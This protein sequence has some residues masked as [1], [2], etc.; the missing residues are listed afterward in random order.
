MLESE[1]LVVKSSS[2]N[3]FSPSAIRVYEIAALDHEVFD[4]SVK[5]YALNAFQ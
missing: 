2:V 1:V 3:G 5:Y 4:T